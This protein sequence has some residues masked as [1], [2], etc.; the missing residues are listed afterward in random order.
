MSNLPPALAADLLARREQLLALREQLLAEINRVVGQ[1]QLADT[2]LAWQG[3]DA[4]PSTEA[5]VSVEAMED[6]SEKYKEQ[7]HD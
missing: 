3:P 2:L 1:L 7:P 4:A 5:F 6:K